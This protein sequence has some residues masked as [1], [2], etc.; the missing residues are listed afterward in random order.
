MEISSIKTEAAINNPA[1][2][3]IMEKLG[4]SRSKNSG[5]VNYAFIEEPVETYVYHKTKEEYLNQK[6]KQ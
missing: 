4:F 2:W 6:A 3:K 1:S 5:Y